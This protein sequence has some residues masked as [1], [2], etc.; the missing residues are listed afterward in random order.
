M[1]YN[2]PIGANEDSNAPWNEVKPIYKD[3][4]VDIVLCRKEKMKLEV[5]EDGKVLDSE[6]QEIIDWAK[7]RAEALD[8]EYIDFEI[9]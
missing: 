3:F 2:T 5:D 8:C 1:S 6:F 4:I 9:L 7:Y